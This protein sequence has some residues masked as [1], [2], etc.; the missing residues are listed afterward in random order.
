MRRALAVVVVVVATVTAACSSGGGSGARAA[1][2]PST[3]RIGLAAPA[4]L[5]P[6][7]AR[8]GSEAVL[9]DMLFD[10]LTALDPAT[11]R[12][13]PRLA[14]RWDVSADLRRF[15]FHLRRG[16]AFSDGRSL[17]AT[18]VVYT[19]TR[20][21]RPDSGVSELLAPALAGI[22]TVQAVD[23]ST[24]VVETAEPFADL[25]ALVASPALGVVPEGWQGGDFTVTSGPF[26]LAGRAGDVIRLRRAR[27]GS[28]RLAAVRVRTGE[29]PA[30][31]AAFA[32]GDLD[33]ALIPAEQAPDLA[34]RTGRAAYAGY[35]GVLFYGFNLA[36]PA[37]KD[38]RLREAVAHAV[39]RAAIA[40]SVYR[41]TVRPIGGPVPAG[42]PGAVVDACGEAC[43]FDPVAARGLVAAAFPSGA[44]RIAVDTEDDPV[45]RGVAAAIAASLRTVGIDATVRTH[46]PG[47]YVRLVAAGGQ[48]LFRLGWAAG[49][50][51]ADAFLRPLFQTGADTNVTGLSV[52]GV[53]AAL[54]ALRVERDGRTRE[55]LAGEVQRRVMAELPIVP[56]AQFETLAFASAR[57]RGLRLNVLGTFDAAGVWLAPR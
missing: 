54:A 8:T 2:V 39:D 9:A 24:V 29:G 12:P 56:I 3:L 16:I 42:I 37:L 17:R 21:R 52:P 35:A 23:P 44:P 50:P 53:D 46:D 33:W 47:E 1:R 26:T 4:T 31:A 51:S 28:A 14:A 45:Q 6:L 15:T 18:D 41:G 48:Q 20:A 32:S 7:R 36:D 11:N 34:A 25:P 55:R 27:P 22:T 40:S 43:R 30:L 19:L 38:R 49:Y 10:G 5:D 57:V 13:E